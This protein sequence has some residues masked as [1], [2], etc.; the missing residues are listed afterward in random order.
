MAKNLPANAEDVKDVGSNP[1]S[2]RS[3]GER[4]GNPL[5]YSCLDSPV[6]SGDWWAVAHSV[7]KSGT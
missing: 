1:E 7:T 5:W 3:P 6:D 4:N 2:G